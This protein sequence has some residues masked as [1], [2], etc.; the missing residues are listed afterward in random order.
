LFFIIIIY[1]HGTCIFTVIFHDL[2]NSPKIFVLSLF[3][4][5][6]TS[7]AY[8]CFNCACCTRTFY[9]YHI[10]LYEFYE[11]GVNFRECFYG[12]YIMFFIG[13]VLLMSR[14]WLRG[15]QVKCF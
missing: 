8:L 7:K 13:I 14:D 10:P 6:P 2:H 9:V 11:L 1:L 5:I 4:L 3:I 15:I 12:L